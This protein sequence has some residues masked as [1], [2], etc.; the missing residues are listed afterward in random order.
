MK[1]AY[2]SLITNNDFM[3]GLIAMLKTYS[4]VKNDIPMYVMVTDRISDINREIIKH[5]GADVIEVSAITL[6]NSYEGKYMD[7]HRERNIHTGMAKLNVFN[8][9]QFDKVVFVDADVLFIR[10]CDELFDKPSFS[11]V[12]DP[13]L[14][15]R[16]D[17]KC[18]DGGNGGMMV[19]EP[20]EAIFNDLMKIFNSYKDKDFDTIND[21]D[22][23]YEY[24][25]NWPER[26]DLHVDIRYNFQANFAG[27]VEFP[28]SVFDLL[29]VKILHMMGLEK[30]WRVPDHRY[31]TYHGGNLFDG[32][33]TLYVDIINF[34]IKDLSIN[35]LYTPDLHYIEWNEI[36]Y[37]RKI[38]GSDY[39]KRGS[40]YESLPNNI[41]ELKF[42]WSQKED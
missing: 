20:S 30:P 4:M 37:T 35:K 22:I 34:C 29:Q 28:F 14:Y 3:Y 17:V 7:P 1:K 39:P 10:N 18:P 9:T 41:F 12:P 13:G 31:F 5:F 23:T 32:L 6:P 15:K 40:L 21:Q 33:N 8:L 19:I 42:P 16:D 24:L 27:T 25:K 11:M 36:P 2:I 38:L 26:E